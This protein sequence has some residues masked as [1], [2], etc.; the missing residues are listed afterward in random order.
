MHSLQETAHECARD[1]IRHEKVNILS[2]EIAREFVSI[3]LFF[4]SI[5]G[6]TKANEKKG[7]G[8]FPL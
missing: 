8:D 4:N 7:L 2:R 1:Y 3:N 6:R 5:Q